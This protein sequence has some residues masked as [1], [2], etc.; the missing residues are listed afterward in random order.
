MV[1]MFIAW[2]IAKNP[3][4]RFIHLSYSDSLA[5]DNSAEIKD[6][7]NSF[8][9]QEL[10]PYVKIKV[11]AKAK[12]KWYTTENGGVLARSSSGQVTGFGAGVTNFED[13]EI[14]EFG[15]A[16][17]IDDPL[18]PDDAHSEVLRERVNT[19]FNTTI[20]NRIN[21][22]ETPIIII[23]QRLH[24]N[25]LCGYLKENE[26][27][28]WQ[29]VEMPVIQEDGTALWNAKHNL[30]QLETMREDLGIIFETQ[31]MQ[32]PMPA[33]GYL[34]PKQN[35][36]LFPNVHDSE[37]IK[38]YCFIDPSEKNGDMMSVIFL[39]SEQFDNKINFHVFDVIHSNKGFELI[40]EIINTKAIEYN[41][42]EVIFEKNGVGLATG[43]KL[44]NLN[45]D[46]KYKLIPY[47]TTENKEAKILKNY[48]YATKYFS[49]N[50]DYE[51]NKNFKVFISD[52]TLYSSEVRRQH[53]ADAMDVVCSATKILKIK[54]D[55]LI[56][57]L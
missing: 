20:R 55:K 44:K 51:S 13:D 17:I 57:I 8:D 5:L 53:K 7:I 46:N 32:N 10:F 36:R 18:K 48:E 24:P 35:L 39:Q 40:S 43:V 25:D 19:K 23:M 27:D 52:L 15:G 34:M 9:Y 2:S 3:S 12:N 4:A 11:D 1:K 45:I 21:S 56:G 26:P 33:D 50:S 41:I 6:I 47:H 28:V 14:V 30:L 31:Y 29:T 54:Y 38:K 49:F 37:K 16:I 22:E 42:D